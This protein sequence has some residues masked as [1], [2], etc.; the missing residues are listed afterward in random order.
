MYPIQELQL[1]LKQIYDPSS[2]NEYHQLLNQGEYT[3]ISLNNNTLKDYQYTIYNLLINSDHF[4]FNMSGNYCTRIQHSQIMAMSRF[5]E[6][7]CSDY[8]EITSDK[9]SVKLE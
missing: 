5:I 4:W 9:V 8:Y 6:K 3:S 7:E 2:K 1:E